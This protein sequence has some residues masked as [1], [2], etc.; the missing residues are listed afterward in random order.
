MCDTFFVVESPQTTLMKCDIRDGGR[1]Y[2]EA[3]ARLDQPS[4]CKAETMIRPSLV[5]LIA[6]WLEHGRVVLCSCPNRSSVP[7]SKISG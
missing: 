7:R 3:S 6:R 5:E 2:S 1:T 4:D